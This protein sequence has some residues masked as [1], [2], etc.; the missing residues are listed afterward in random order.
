MGGDPTGER[1]L[2]SGMILLCWV[3]HQTGKLS[4]HAGN[5][6]TEPLSGL[7]NNGPVAW[8]IAATDLLPILVKSGGGCAVAVNKDGRDWVEVAREREVQSLE[9][10]EDWQRRVL[11]YLA[12]RIR[13]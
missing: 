8:Y 1:S 3:R 10:L 9:P 13:R 12:E 6:R 4:R 5:L 2:P 11:E 7:G